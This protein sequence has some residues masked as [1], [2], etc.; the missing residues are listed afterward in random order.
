MPVVAARRIVTRIYNKAAVSS[1]NDLFSDQSF[2]QNE[3]TPQLEEQQ[4]QHQQNLQQD[5]EQLLDSFSTNNERCR[6]AFDDEK[7]TM[8]LEALES[9]Q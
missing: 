2:E 8:A 9:I 7:M 6:T 3:H 5:Q 1:S 4:Q